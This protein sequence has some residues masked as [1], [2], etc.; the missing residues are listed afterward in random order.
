MAENGFATL[1]QN[2]QTMVIAGLDREI[3][4]RTSLIE[5][6]KSTR[7]PDQ[8]SIDWWEGDIVASRNLRDRFLHFSSLSP[9]ASRD[10]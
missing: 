6:E 8:N 5:R 2:V 4:D 7:H 10:R 1:P 3:A 9:N